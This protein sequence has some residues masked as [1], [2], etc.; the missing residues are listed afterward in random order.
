[1]KRLLLAILTVV[2]GAAL[3]PAAHALTLFELVS[4]GDIY[5]SSDTGATWTGKAVLPIHDAI[6]LAAGQTS[7]QLFLAT[8]SGSVYR[9]TDAGTTWAASLV[10]PASD[11]VALAI[12]PNDAALLLLTGSGSVYLATYPSYGSF[13]ALAALTGSNFVSIAATP[14]GVLYALTQTGDVYESTNGGSTWTPKGVIT[15]SEAVGI[16]SFGGALYAISLSGDVYKST[17]AGSTWTA[18]GTLSQVG[19]SGLAVVGPYLGAAFETSEMATSPDGV[20]WRGRGLPGQSFVRALG[21]DTPGVT[22][23]GQPPAPGGPLALRIGPNPRVG[24]APATVHITLERAAAVM[25]SLYDANGR[26][27]ARRD[28]EPLATGQSDVAWAPAIRASGVYRVRA[29]T[30]DGAVARAVWVALR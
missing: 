16:Q 6:A 5:A 12:R 30:S 14:G 25:L 27:V 7:S 28:A 8:T 26:L 29:E 21:T 17:N 10:A 20:T 19:V 9:S 15:T 18:V 22:G 1:M 11:V 4:T 13:T 3:A 23:I 24:D 2:L